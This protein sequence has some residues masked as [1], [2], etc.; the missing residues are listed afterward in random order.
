MTLLS[1][2]PFKMASDSASQVTHFWLY[3]FSWA[4]LRISWSAGRLW[5]GW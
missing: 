1:Q 3:W 5:P 4:F 2:K